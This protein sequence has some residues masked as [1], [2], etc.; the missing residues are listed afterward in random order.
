MPTRT[1]PPPDRGRGEPGRDDADDDDEAQQ[2]EETAP[3]PAVDVSQLQTAP[4]PPLPLAR[5]PSR[6]P[7]LPDDTDISEAQ[8]AL[9]ATSA[10]ARDT[11]RQEMIQQH[12]DAAAKARQRAAAQQPAIDAQ[13]VRVRLLTARLDALRRIPERQ[14]THTNTHEIGA[15]AVG[16]TEQDAELDRLRRAQ[17]V[18]TEEEIH[19]AMAADELRRQLET[20]AHRP[21]PWRQRRPSHPRDG[22]E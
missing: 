15:L 6:P 2:H 9:L 18:D 1:P 11:L 19:H 17:W 3:A 12:R 21:P 13:A 4:L 8:T 20:P 14:R 10:S 5:P 16:I 7:D 22:Q